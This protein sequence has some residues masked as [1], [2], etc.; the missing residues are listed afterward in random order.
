MKRSGAQILQAADVSYSCTL[1][2]RFFRG[3]NIR[4]KNSKFETRPEPPEFLSETFLGN[5][6]N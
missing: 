1:V 5:L 2:V 3:K 4:E 6:N